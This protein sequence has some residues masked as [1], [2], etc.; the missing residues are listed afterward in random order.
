MPNSLDSSKTSAATETS[1]I[2]RVRDLPIYYDAKSDDIHRF[3]P[4]TAEEEVKTNTT[5]S[6]LYPIISQIRQSVQQTWTE[7]KEL[8][9]R[10]ARGIET[11]GAHTRA[12]IDYI[13]D[14]ETFL[15]K[16]GVVTIAGLGG[17]LLGHKGGAVR[18]TFY[19]S[20]AALVA[21]SA[22]YPK[23]SANILD[24]VYVRVKNESKNLL[25]KTPAAPTVRIVE[26]KDRI[27]H[28]VKT[29]NEPIVTVQGDYGQGSPADQH[30]YT[31][32]GVANPVVLDTEKKL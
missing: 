18:K 30:L 9:Q 19:S 16:V 6:W 22:C 8:R 5:N 23:Q 2:I 3:L 31:T 7:N 4:R 25:D 21:L 12:T 13:R 29:A 20:V 27:L 28:S 10:I 26:N 14:D 11:G 24:Q 1:R 32:R 15:P 17:L